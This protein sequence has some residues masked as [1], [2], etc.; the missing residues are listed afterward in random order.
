[1]QQLVE[2]FRS[3]F[4]PVV[5]PLPVDNVTPLKNQAM[6]VVR[7]VGQ[8]LNS[9]AQLSPPGQFIRRV[10][11]TAQYTYQPKPMMVPDSENRAFAFS[12]MGDTLPAVKLAG[13]ASKPA[14]VG[15]AAVGGL[16]TTVKRLLEKEQ[17]KPSTA[18]GIVAD[19][20]GGARGAAQ[21]APASL[22]IP[23]LPKRGPLTNRPTP[24]GTESMS[25][26]T[27]KLTPKP[28]GTGWNVDQR[29]GK[30]L[31]TA[32][33]AVKESRPA[34]QKILEDLWNKGDLKGAQ[35]VIDSMAQNDPY[36]SSMQMLQKMKLG[37]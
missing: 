4:S 18:L 7:D 32:I 34:H 33:K 5:S 22:L 19:S 10:G 1:M 17:I 37:N 31:Q 28:D 36:K 16:L 20:I 12:D 21:F 25:G 2:S 14:L 11:T 9:A 8:G 30:P 13:Y 35:K 27:M 29:F 3:A 15:G 26:R 23:F 6:G 24:P